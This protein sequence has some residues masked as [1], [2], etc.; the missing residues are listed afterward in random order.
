MKGLVLRDLLICYRRTSKMNYITDVIFFLFF[1]LVLR[2]HYRCIA[3]FMCDA[4]KHERYAY[5]YEGDGCESKRAL[6]YQ[7]ISCFF[8]KPGVIPLCGCFIQQLHYVAMM[9]LYILLHAVSVSR[10][11][12]WRIFT[13][14]LPCMDDGNFICSYQFDCLFYFQLKCGSYTLC[15]DGYSGSD[16]LFIM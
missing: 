5:R 1:L 13:D 12:L 3:L 6:A 4:F 9:L 14:V 10:I 11:F 8:Q 16:W 7:P 15:R 2:N